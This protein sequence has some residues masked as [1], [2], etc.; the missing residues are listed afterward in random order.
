MKATG[1]VVN[2]GLSEYE[3]RLREDIASIRGLLRGNC[4]KIGVFVAKGGTGKSTVATLLGSILAEFRS[5]DRVI[6]VDA[7]P[8]FGKLANRIAPE[9]TQ[10]F[11]ELLGD[12]SAGRLTRWTDVEAHLGANNNTGLWLLRG[13]HRTHG[14]RIIDGPTIAGALKVVDRYMR[15]AVIDCG[16]VLD[17]PVMSAV[18]PTL[19]AA[20]IVGA[21]EP[22]ASQAAGETLAWLNESGYHRLLG[23]TA[24]VLND[25][26]GRSSK[27]KRIAL[28]REFSA[29]TDGATVVFPFD[30]HLS[31]GGVIDT[32]N[33]K[34]GVSS[35]TRRAAIGLGACVAAGFATTTLEPE[36][37]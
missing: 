32:K 8:S 14:R 25:P 18:L 11:W 17:H 5:K 28:E 16:Q 30:E 24:V 37:R 22:A 4:Y 6:A 35:R 27:S 19:D 20:V 29:H 9:T 12:E 15:I 10:T 31:A 2:P 21:M 3:E 33:A 26:R 34:S 7:D 23:K 13:E 36:L 1:G